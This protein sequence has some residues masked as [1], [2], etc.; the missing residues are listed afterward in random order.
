[1]LPGLFGSAAN[2]V[3][4]M[5]VKVDPSM[6]ALKALVAVMTV[7]IVAGVVGIVVIIA[8]RLSTG[9]KSWPIAGSPPLAA[10]PGRATV[11]LP[12]GGRVMGIAGVGE[13]LVMHVARPEGPDQLLVIDPASGAVLQTLDLTPG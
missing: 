8:G 12:P 7:L 3:F 2:S 9:S 5:I 10:A 6:R 1:L 4:L 13:R 11:P